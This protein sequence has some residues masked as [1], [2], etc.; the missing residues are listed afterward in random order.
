MDDP[1]TLEVQG[2]EVS[3]A[4]TRRGEGGSIIYWW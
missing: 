3:N 2:T 4:K 1:H